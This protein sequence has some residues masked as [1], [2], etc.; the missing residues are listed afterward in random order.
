MDASVISALAAL[1]GAI[2]GGLTSVFTAWLAQR[3][4]ARAQEK[5]RRQELYKEFIEEA[6]KCHIDALQH[7][8]ADIASL[9]RLYAKMH[10]MRLGSSLKVVEH[11][12]QIG[13]KI[14]DSYLKPDKTFLELHEMV[15]SRSIN[16]LGD[17]SEACR[18]ELD[19][20]RT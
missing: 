6:T 18:A 10:T 1:G 20:L 17:F 12:E 8:E 4:Q 9:V 7:H 15:A 13:Q 11:A 2:I 19:L 14:L 3:T 5:L 16:I